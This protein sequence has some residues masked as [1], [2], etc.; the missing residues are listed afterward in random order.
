MIGFSNCKNNI[1]TSFASTKGSI[2][3]F[4]IYLKKLFFFLIGDNFLAKFANFFII[5]FTRKMRL[6]YQFFQ[7][8]LLHPRDI[9]LERHAFRRL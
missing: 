2:V 8:T 9:A 7:R 1:L 5:E 6:D 3:G 4:M